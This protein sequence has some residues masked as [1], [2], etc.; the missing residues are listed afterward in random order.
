M[1]PAQIN[2]RA[3]NKACVIKWKKAIEG[4]FKARVN[5]I[6]ATC[7]RVDKA[8]IFFISH[9]AMALAL[10]ISMVIVPTIRRNGWYSGH[11]DIRGKNR[12]SKYTPAVTSVEE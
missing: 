8:I 12:Y 5:I 9:S 2:S 10:A 7:L 1:F 4:M 11:R 3:L 6:S